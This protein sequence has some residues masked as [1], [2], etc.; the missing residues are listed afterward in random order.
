MSSLGQLVAGVAHE[1][2]NPI[3]FIHG[4]LPHIQSYVQDL[5]GLVS[6][7]QQHYSHPHPQIQQQAEA[8]DFE[9]IVEDLPNVISS[10]EVGTHRIRQL[11]LSLQNFSRKELGKK[12]F[13]DIHRGID[14]T[15][16]ILQ[17]RL[18]TK[19][20]NPGIQVVKEYGNLPPVPCY[21]GALNQVFMNILTNAI[22]ALEQATQKRSSS[23]LEQ[24]PNTIIIRTGIVKRTAPGEKTSV[25]IRISD[26]GLGIPPAILERIFDPFFTTKPM[27]KGTGL[28]LSISYQIVVEKHGGTLKCFSEP[29]KGTEFWIEIPYS[30]QTAQG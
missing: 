14:D 15:L 23:R 24:Q 18:K 9:F 4:N 12:E 8:I 10:I 29:G 13:V 27:G 20:E 26:N 22:N 6:L 30:V 28:G 1:I 3:T 11:V 21:A 17:H 25:V 2:N 5:L 19:G 16:L 7:Y